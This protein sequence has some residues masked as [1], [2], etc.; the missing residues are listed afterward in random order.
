MVYGKS[1]TRGVPSAQSRKRLA[2]DLGSA[3]EMQGNFCQYSLYV[4]FRFY[5]FHV[6]PNIFITQVLNIA[7]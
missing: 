1:G 4:I 7:F 6:F 3:V 5:F 2:I